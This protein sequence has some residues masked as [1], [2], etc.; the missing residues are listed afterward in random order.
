MES[1]SAIPCM[2]N[3][4]SRWKKRSG[5]TRTSLGFAALAAAMKQIDGKSGATY[6][7]YSKALKDSAK[8]KKGAN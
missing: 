5:K 4:R 2:R 3:C 7:L 1:Q 6:K 8:I